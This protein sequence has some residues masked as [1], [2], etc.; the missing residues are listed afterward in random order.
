MEGSPFNQTT[1]KAVK[2]CII[3]TLI[4]SLVSPFLTFILSHFFHLS[5]PSLWLSLS[6]YGLKEGWLFEPLT[7]FF[8]HTSS[9]TISLSLLLTLFFQMLLLFIAGR[10][11]ASRFGSLSFLSLYLGG[12]L[13]SGIVGSLYLL[14]TGS[15]EVL[16]G[17]SPAVFALLAAWAL[18]LEHYQLTLFFF[19]RMGA[20]AIVIL[21]F[22]ISLLIHL[23][24]F[25]WLFLIAEVAGL[26]FGI[27]Y[28]WLIMRRTPKLSLYTKKKSEHDI[29]VEVT[30]VEEPDDEFMDRM[31][32][33]ISSEGKEALTKKEKDRMN[34]IA[35]KRSK[36]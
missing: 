16:Y 27:T 32:E 15:S 12:G 10:D 22:V 36:P 21:L 13:F 26:L 9:A 24:H 28:A 14:S 7:Y 1:P 11:L 30:P 19:I 4:T 18:R 17:S 8:I 31:L 20:R 33:K 23:I 34:E 35:K 3:F 2:Y 29:E 5:G 25:E 6:T